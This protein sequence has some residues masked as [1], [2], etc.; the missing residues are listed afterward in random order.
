[1]EN[2]SNYTFSEARIS[3]P[4]R[5]EFIWEIQKALVLCANAQWSPNAN[6]NSNV[7]IYVFRNRRIAQFEAPRLGKLLVYEVSRSLRA[8]TLNYDSYTL[9]VSRTRLSLWKLACPLKTKQTRPWKEK[10]SARDT[11]H[12]GSSR[13]PF[14][15]P[16][17][18]PP[19]AARNF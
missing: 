4:R 7:T 2:R 11:P 3:I 15:S 1:M 9:R 14:F 13:S 17:H 19:R 5:D 10:L 6:R 12:G 8:S 16:D 18:N